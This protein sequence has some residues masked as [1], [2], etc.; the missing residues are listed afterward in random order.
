VTFV[1]CARSLGR[2]VIRE[3]DGDVDARLKYAFRLYTARVPTQRELA[4]LRQLYEELYALCEADLEGARNLAGEP[5]LPEGASVAQMATWAAVGR[6]LL[7]LDEAV[8]RE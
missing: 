8:T 2:R 4:R 5:Q 1:E 7:N 3:C 6:A